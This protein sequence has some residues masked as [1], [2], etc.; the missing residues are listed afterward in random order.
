M[1]KKAAQLQQHTMVCSHLLPPPQQE[2]ISLPLMVPPSLLRAGRDPMSTWEKMIPRF[3]EHGVC[4]T[5]HQT[6]PEARSMLLLLVTKNFTNE[7]TEVWGLGV[8][9]SRGQGKNQ[10]V[11]PAF[12]LWAVSSASPFP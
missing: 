5:H 6:L 3:S 7:D 4:H 9:C 11:C 8:C 12:P 2:S 1:K 10:F